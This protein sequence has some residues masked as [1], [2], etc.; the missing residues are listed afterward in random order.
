V[1][2]EV[3]SLAPLPNAD[4]EWFV[5]VE[6]R[7]RFFFLSILDFGIVVVFAVKNDVSSFPTRGIRDGWFFFFGFWRGHH[8]WQDF[9]RFSVTF[10]AMGCLSL[11]AAPSWHFNLSSC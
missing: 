6:C 1:L 9:C 5:G 10:I 2:G 7:K 4:N 11:A 3:D 8:R